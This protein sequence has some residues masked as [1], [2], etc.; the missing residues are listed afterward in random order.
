MAN[1]ITTV[2]RGF[3]RIFD[4]EGCHREY[5]SSRETE[6][7]ILPLSSTEKVSKEN[8]L[9]VGTDL[10]SEN[11]EC[12]ICLEDY[13]AGQK[14]SILS[15]MH[16]YHENCLCTWNNDHR[17]CPQCRKTIKIVVID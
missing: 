5:K 13:K 6:D 16:F 1:V 10:A 8:P 15:C 11:I 12:S 7:E 4:C 14:L 17:E 2:V 3:F 9:I